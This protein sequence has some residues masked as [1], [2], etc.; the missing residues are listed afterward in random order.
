MGLEKKFIISL[1]IIGIEY[2]VAT[3]CSC[4]CICLKRILKHFRI[5]KIEAIEMLRHNNSTLTV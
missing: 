2:I 5:E 3:F 4:Q 1:S